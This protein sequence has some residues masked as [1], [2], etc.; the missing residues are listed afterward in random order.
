MASGNVDILEEHLW[1]FWVRLGLLLAPL[2][3]AGLTALIVA[4]AAAAGR[5]IA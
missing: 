3:L 2:A 1:R 5:T 4:V